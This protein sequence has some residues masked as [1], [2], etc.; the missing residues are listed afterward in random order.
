MR[1]RNVNGAEE[2]IESH[3]SIVTPNHETHKGSWDKVFGNSNPIHIEI[4]MGKGQF[5]R[6]MALQ[7]PN[8][9]FIGVEYY[10]SVLVRALEK[11]IV[12]DIPNVRLL[13]LDGE[14]LPTGFAPQE[15]SRIYLN[16]SDPWPKIRHAKRRL[17]HERF[18]TIYRDLLASEGDLWFKTDNR[19][20]FQFSL[21]SMNNF[22]MIFEDVSLNLHEEE[23]TDNIRTEYEQ[24]WSDRGFPIYRVEARFNRKSEK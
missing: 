10:D 7:N 14:H 17:T 22:G 13:R 19:L 4:G 15:L 5:I 16:F 24:N 3:P 9:N 21:V 18:L 20:L 1:L 11:F 2:K 12:E 8:I 23:P 6:G